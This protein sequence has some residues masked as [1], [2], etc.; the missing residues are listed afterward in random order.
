MRATHRYLLATPWFDAPPSIGGL[1][2]GT[3]SGARVLCEIRDY[4]FDSFLIG[5]AVLVFIVA[6]RLIASTKSSRSR[7][8]LRLDHYLPAVRRLKVGEE[9]FYG[10]FLS[11]L[12]SRLPAAFRSNYQSKR[13]GEIRCWL[14]KLGPSWVLSPN[15]RVIQTLAFFAFLYSF[16][17]VCWPYGAR[18]APDA[19]LTKGWKLVEI[20]QKSGS[21]FFEADDSPDWL[22]GAKSLWLQ[23]IEG[24]GFVELSLIEAG[25]KQLQLELPNQVSNSLFDAF[26]TRQASWD[27][28]DRRPDEWPAHYAEH[29]AAR[30][31]LPVDLFLVIDPLVGLSTAIASRSWVW[32]LGCAGVILAVSF[33]VP[34]GFC[35]Y[36]CPLGTTIDLFDFLVGRRVKRFRV[37]GEGWWVHVKYYLLAATL[38]AATMGVLLT[39]FVSA[40]PVIT[41][42]CLLIGE[43]VQTGLARGWHLV[44]ATG[45]GHYLSIVLFLSILA[46]GFFRER[47][48][49][50]Y[51][52]PS[53]AVFSVSN[54]FRWTDRKVEN[55]C[56]HCNKCVE[57]CPFDA[58]KPD[59]TTRGTDC[60]HCQTC[61]GAC[62]TH[63]I[64]FVERWNVVE[65]KVANDPPTGESSIGRRGFLSL[66]GGSVAASVG[67]VSGAIATGM[68]SSEVNARGIL[69]VRPPGSVPEDSFLDLCI[70]C[71]ECFKVCPNNVLQA[72]GLEYGLAGLW[73]PKVEA[74]WA[75][76]DSSC[77]ACGQVCPTGAI[78][79]LT[80]DEKRV[81]RM[82]LAFVNEQTCL[83]YAGDGDCDYCVK[84]CQA[85][86]YDAIEYLQVGTELD[87]QGQPIA[88]SGFLAP[89]VLGDRC[90][91]C[92]L[93]QTRCFAINVKELGLLKESAIVI[94]AGEGKED[95]LF[96]GESIQSYSSPKDKAF[97]INHPDF[98]AFDE[99]QVDLGD[100]NLSGS[101]NPRSGETGLDDTGPED[102]D[103]PFG[104]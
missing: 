104:L 42:A 35:G 23:E 49:C 84:E 9:P 28:Y 100:T 94:E 63:A 48:W 54:L 31:R 4:D 47:F 65:L 58:I 2:S 74:D 71:G 96:T 60:T 6:Y 72:Q 16:F 95:R 3:P 18:P 59:F 69:P 80:I 1:V 32:S 55:S 83:P 81:T 44:P 77:N 17:Y 10:R 26:L 5:L 45:F 78:R 66:A 24:A 13:R 51:V 21:L 68:L 79:S 99:S 41:R 86:G 19:K 70:R 85:A 34:R 97:G 8:L 62:P 20:E 15:R 29:F 73:A 93:C 14:R 75:G 46:L 67:G 12:R 76:C 27:F 87:E 88:D 102:T 36:L 64:K 90:V 25:A 52:C 22:L 101:Q 53:G 11:Q 89:V 98:Q 56:I 40:I 57:V 39:G 38:F 7:A 30:E 37:E 50:K 61:A 82:G 43:P 91:G 33:L 92:G 103:N